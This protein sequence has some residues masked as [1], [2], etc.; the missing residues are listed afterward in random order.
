M[1]ILDAL[2]KAY[3][4]VCQEKYQR[5]VRANEKLEKQVLCLKV[6]AWMQQHCLLGK[7]W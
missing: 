1:P 2:M 4:F 5:A 7:M 3:Q 6:S